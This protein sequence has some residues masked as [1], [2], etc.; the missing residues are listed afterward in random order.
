MFTA[1]SR[2]FL[3]I[4]FLLCFAPLALK[5]V[6][7]FRTLGQI[8][9]ESGSGSPNACPVARPLNRSATTQHPGPRN[10]DRIDIFGLLDECNDRQQSLGSSLAQLREKLAVFD[11]DTLDGLIRKCAALDVPLEE[12][13]NLLSE[14][15]AAMATKDPAGTVQTFIDAIPNGPDFWTLVNRA[16]IKRPFVLWM[17]SDL[18]GAFKWFQEN[19]TTKLHTADDPYHHKLSVLRNPLVNSL[20]LN[21]SPELREFLLAIP[22]EERGFLAISMPG[23]VE[24]AVPDETTGDDPLDLLPVYLPIIREYLP[25]GHHPY[26][27]KRL[28]YALACRQQ[29]NGLADVS[30]FFSEVQLQPDEAERIA[31]EIGGKLL[32]LDARLDTEGLSEHALQ[33]LVRWLDSEFPDRADSIMEQARCKALETETEF[34]RWIIAHLGSSNTVNG[35]PDKKIADDLTKYSMKSQVAQALKIAETIKETELRETV[36]NHLKQQQPV[37][38]E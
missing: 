19:Q 13:A 24:C 30:R 18:E 7:M 21:D 23:P 37:P 17:Q 28:A 4:I 34:A 3:A 27:F 31:S 36:I 32:S 25:P 10:L 14:L 2:Y 15:V 11:L 1:K 20:V 35:W 22:Y 33:E 5:Q 12:K 29:A 9:R 38:S 6:M 8:D 16:N 26:A